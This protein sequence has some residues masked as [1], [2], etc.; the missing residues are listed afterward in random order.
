MNHTLV[1]LIHG[2]NVRDSGLGSIQKLAPYF[3]EWPGTTVRAFNYGWKFLLGVRKW[4]DDLAEDLAQQIHQSYD[5]GYKRIIVVGHS[6]GCAIAHLASFH[7]HLPVE[8]V[9]INPALERELVPS[10]MVSRIDVWH[11][12]KD[13]AVAWSR[14]LFIP[15]S[16]RPWGLMGKCGYKGGDDRFLNYDT[17]N[18]FPYMA[19][20]HS[21]VFSRR[22]IG[23]Y[24]PTIVRLTMVG[25]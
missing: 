24:G 25:R 21:A 16:N 10:Q 20:G 7:L 3:R 17:I 11:N 1:I 6:N 13:K 19:K 15:S 9:Y 22:N 12:R 5:Q 23:F 2:F 18:D 8:Y 14:L 4:N